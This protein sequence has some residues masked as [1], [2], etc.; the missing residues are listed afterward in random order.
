M[1]FYLIMTFLIGFCVIDYKGKVSYKILILVMFII[2]GFATTNVD[3]PAYKMMY[4]MIN[5]IGDLGV[6]DF[7]FSLL[8]LISKTLGLEFYAF[9]RLITIIG[10]LVILE[11]I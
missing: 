2:M 8:A 11:T 7:G 1:L 6:T 3:M 10:L 4:S 5:T 9:L